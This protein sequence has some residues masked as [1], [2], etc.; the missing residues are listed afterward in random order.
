MP[1]ITAPTRDRLVD[2]L[3]TLRCVAD[4]RREDLARDESRL[5]QAERTGFRLS[6]AR[7]V[8]D[9]SL[10][11]V[12]YCEAAVLDVEAELDALD[13]HGPGCDGPL[14]C[15]CP[16]VDLDALADSLGWPAPSGTPAGPRR[17]DTC[18]RLLDPEADVDRDVCVVCSPEVDDLPPAFHGDYTC[19]TPG[20][21]GDVRS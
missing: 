1:T 5:A 14:N 17:C 16:D 15:T 18:G 7:A 8:R 12:D 13:D 19:G 2:R 10:S 3:V 21:F 4:L 6:Q 20:A 11:I 9:L